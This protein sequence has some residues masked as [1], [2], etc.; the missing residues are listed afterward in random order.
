MYKVQWHPASQLPVHI[1]Y[2][3]MLTLVTSHWSEGSLVRKVTIRKTANKQ[4]CSITH[5]VC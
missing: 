1:C 2:Q 5:F 4:Q 3:Q